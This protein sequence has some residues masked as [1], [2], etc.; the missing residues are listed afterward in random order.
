MNTPQHTAATRRSSRRRRRVLVG[1]ASALG[2]VVGPL[3]ATGASA[4]TSAP[5]G[6]ETIHV[7]FLTALSGPAAAANK[8]LQD[9]AQAAVDY[10]NAGNS[11]NAGA[12]YE[13]EVRDTGG[14]PNKTAVLIRELLDGGVDVMLGEFGGAPGFLAEQP[15]LNERPV[16][17]FTS[18]PAD[19]IWQDA[20]IG[21]AY[22]WAFGI[23]GDQTAFATP[24]IQAAFDRT[25]VA[26]IAQLYPNS[27]SAPEWAQLTEPLGQEQGIAVESK[28]FA[29]NATD[30]KSQL[31]DLQES[32]ADTLIIW[33]YGTAL[34][35]A[36]TNL[37]ELGWYPNIVTLP[38]AGRES[39]IE[40]VPADVMENVVGGPGGATFGS[41]CGGPAS[42]VTAT[43]LE[44]LS[45]V[46]GRGA[47]EYQAQDITSAYTFDSLLAYDDALAE[48]GSTDPEAV[49]D[50]LQTGSFTGAMG[51]HSWTADARSGFEQ[52]EFALF[53]PLQSCSEGTCVAPA[54]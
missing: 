10:L 1:T 3:I 5:G 12:T 43:F 26:Q 32:G 14:D 38:D 42:G 46:T 23:V 7:G 50:A 54:S 2:L 8:P 28:E 20:G 45:E 48:A 24:L 53:D 39:L 52:S 18:A 31:R 34:Q 40:A 19:S 49:R 41:A 4:T 30:V 25:E 11:Q 17:A 36:L 6:P 37:D 47:G 21:K 22:P 33:T 15:A 9:G 35:T 13:L 51:E 27:G 16:P 44:A 29:A